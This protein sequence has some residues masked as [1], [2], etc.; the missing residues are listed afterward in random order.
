MLTRAGANDTGNG[1]EVEARTPLTDQLPLGPGGIWV[2]EG[3]PP[4]AQAESREGSVEPDTR[5]WVQ[6]THL[7]SRCFSRLRQEGPQEFQASLGYPVRPCLNKQTKHPPENKA[8]QISRPGVHSTQ[9]PS[10]E[11]ADCSAW[12][13]GRAENQR[14]RCRLT[15]EVHPQWGPPGCLL[16]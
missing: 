6:R 5:E 15:L 2:E 12:L 4:Q 8:L 3:A 13:V 11:A 9:D 16:E 10:R 1:G 7:S 14:P